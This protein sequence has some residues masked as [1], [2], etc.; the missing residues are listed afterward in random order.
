MNGKLL[1]V[2]IGIRHV[3]CL[4][5]PQSPK[6]EAE[7]LKNKDIQNLVRR[8]PLDPPRGKLKHWKV[9]KFKT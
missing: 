5:P 4:K 9:R 8:S 7:V 2:E 6:G 3:C 1:E